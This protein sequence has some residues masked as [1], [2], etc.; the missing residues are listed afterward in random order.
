MPY[1]RE[2]NKKIENQYIKLIRFFNDGKEVEMDQRMKR[3]DIEDGYV[4][5]PDD[6]LVIYNNNPDKLK[7]CWSCGSKK[8]ICLQ[9]TSFSIFF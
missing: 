8:R 6:W 5:F 2:E 3:I 1:E 9:C 7:I 4:I